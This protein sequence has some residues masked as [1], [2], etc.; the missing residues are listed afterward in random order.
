MTKVALL[1]AGGKMGVRLSTNLQGSRFDV[2]HVEVSG[3][4]H[5]RLKAAIGAD[6]VDMDRALAEADVVLM[7]VPDRLIGKIAHEIIGKV[8]PEHGAHR[9][10]RRR[11][12]CGRDA[13]AGGCDLLR[14]PSMPPAHLQRRDGPRGEG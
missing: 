13:G 8:R 4:G 6:C 11:P 12:L 10:R 3:A 7:A 14:D 1:G 2:D 9:A 5:E